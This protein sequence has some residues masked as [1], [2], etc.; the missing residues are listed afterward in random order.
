MR[1]FEQI[2][3]EQLRKDAAPRTE[4]NFIGKLPK[5]ATKNSAGYD[6]F[7]PF[8]FTLEP[9]E[10]IKIPTGVRVKMMPDE[11]LAIFPR[12]GLGFKYYSRLANTIG[13]VDSDYYNSSNEGHVFVKLRNEG[14]KT[15]EVRGGE[16]FCQGIFMKYLL[17]DDDDFDK[18]EDRDG[19]FGS[20][21]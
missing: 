19:G 13:I 20:T 16:A 9:G 15:L 3:V 21:T 5:R 6:F 8:D 12:S 11:F 4:Y 18:G 2:S 1:R 14:D 10:E 7:A 17:V